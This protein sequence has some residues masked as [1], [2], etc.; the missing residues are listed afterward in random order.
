MILILEKED[1]VY[2]E[3]KKKSVKKECWI[4]IMLQA[5]RHNDSLAPMLVG[6]AYRLI[7]QIRDPQTYLYQRIWLR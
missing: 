5:H 2:V 3:K 6:A 4:N 1:E 7:N